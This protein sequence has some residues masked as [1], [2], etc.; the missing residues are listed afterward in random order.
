MIPIKV[1]CG[2]GQLYQFEVEP[3]NGRL[4]GTVACPVCGVDGTEAAN[5]AI[6]QQMAEQN[7]AASA[8]KSALH[9]AKS[10]HSGSQAA[11]HASSRGAATLQHWQTDRTQA[12]FEARAKIS[13]G[14]SPQSVLGYLM[15]QGF[16]RQEASELVNELAAERA[17]EMRG[18]GIKN[19]FLGSGLVLLP[20]VS[21]VVFWII[22]AIPLKIFG[23]MVAGGFYGIWLI[24]RGTHMLIVPKSEGGD[25]AEK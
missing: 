3:V 17:L 8:T 22:G 16:S 18:K 19:I 12:K 14:D 7:S 25:V 6:A 11:T 24:I 1:Q 10:T 20:I 15:T 23:L 21:F 9:L 4:A 13:W 5:E 2:C